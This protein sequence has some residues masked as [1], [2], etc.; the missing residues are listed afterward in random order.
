MSEKNPHTA[1][2]SLAL[3]GNALPRQCGIATFTTDL[4]TALTEESLGLDCGVVAMNDAGKRHA[5]DESV[6]F[7]VSQNEVSSYLRAADFLNVGGFDALCLQHEYGIFGGRAGSHVLSALAQLRIPIVTTVHTVL[8]DPSPDQRAVMDSI[9]RLS[10]RVV[11]MSR[12]GA[13]LLSEIHGVSPEKID[14]IPH[15]IPVLPDREVSRAKLRVEHSLQLLT[16]GLLSPDKGLEYVIDALPDVIARFPKTE[17]VIVGATHPH[18]KKSQGEAYRRSLQLRAHKLGVADHVVFHDRFVSARA[19]RE[20]LSAADL[21][22]TPYLNPE[23]ITSGTLAYAV[24]TGKPVISTPYKYARELLAGERGVLVPYRDSQAI[25]KALIRLL[26]APEELKALG[27]RAASLGPEMTWPAVAEKY[28]SCFALALSQFAAR[29]RAR[30]KKNRLC[31]PLVRLPDLS[32]RH[33]ESMTDDTGMLQHAVFSVPRYQDGYCIDDNARALLL[34]TLMDEAGTDD[35]ETTRRLSTKYLAFISHAFNPA[36]LRFRNFM[37]YSRRWTE[38]SGSEDSHGRTLWALGAV[39]GHAPNKKT[40][41]SQLFRDALPA[42]RDFKSPRA[43]SFALLGIGAYMQA[44][45]GDREVEGIQS[46]LAGQLLARF[47]RNFDQAWPWCEASLTYDNARLA[48]ALIVSGQSLDDAELTRSGVEAL[49]WLVKRQTSDDNTFSPVGS[50]GFY[51]R[52]GKK[53]QFDQQPIEACAT[54]S[55]CFD[56]WHAT[57]NDVWVAEM[58][59][60]FSWFLGENDS[61]T[62]LYDPVTRGCR[63]GLESD[64]A[65]ENQGAES[66]LSFLLALVDMRLMA[67]ETRLKSPHRDEEAHSIPAEAAIPW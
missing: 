65:N 48:Q 6:V 31:G 47:S 12:T 37:D 2:Q 4:L 9:L 60:A 43:C 32:L 19:L 3:W 46:L 39:V 13:S 64:G 8:S 17:Y 7:E 24:G 5:Y 34:T 28:R 63:D 56:A 52:G 61:N 62:A 35:P 20:F 49:E 53:A 18:V 58:W 45:E 51:P 25:S 30:P 1:V 67:T 50:D 42:V 57:G 54:V 16:F 41:A 15:G 22:L 14:I 26:G 27:A 59:R 36:T 44:F 29:R 66:T 38:D 23:Q 33:V 40:L 55:A 10:T 21:Y 11:T